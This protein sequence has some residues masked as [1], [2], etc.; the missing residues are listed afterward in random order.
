MPLLPLCCRRCQAAA[1][2]LPHWLCHQPAAALPPC[3]CTAAAA[4]TAALHC[5]CC[6]AAAKLPPRC[7]PASAAALLPPPSCRRHL[8]HTATAAKLPLLLPCCHCRPR[9]RKAAAIA[10]KLPAATELPPLCCRV[11]ADVAKLSATA[12]LPLLPLRCRTAATAP[13]LP[14]AAKLP[15]AAKLPPSCCQAAAKLPG[16]TFLVVWLCVVCGCVIS[17]VLYQNINLLVLVTENKIYINKG[18]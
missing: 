8:H 16:V 9:C 3:C 15:S 4:A 18:K 7:R 1:V 14:A 10:A 12:K 6:Q 11:A 13:K 17:A 5:R 2:L